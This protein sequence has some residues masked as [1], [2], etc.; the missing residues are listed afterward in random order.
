VGYTLEFHAL[1]WRRLSA[2]FGSGDAALLQTIEA[3]EADTRADVDP[4]GDQPAD[5][6]WRPAL[7]DLILGNLGSELNARDA[8]RQDRP[9]REVAAA[10]AEALVAIVRHQGSFLGGLRHRSKAGGLFREEFLGDAAPR[11]LQTSVDLT[12]LCDRPLFGLTCL[13]FPSWGGLSR[14]EVMAITQGTTSA[15]LPRLPDPDLA[16]WLFDLWDVLITTREHGTDL[17]TLYL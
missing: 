3:A 6:S 14:D 13:P 1:S 17:V 11:A 16:A 4:G 5:E 7:R 10:T 2:V 12:L 15:A 8:L 9:A